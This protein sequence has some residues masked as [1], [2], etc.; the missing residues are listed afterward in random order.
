MN[1]EIIKENSTSLEELLKEAFGKNVENINIEDCLNKNIRF[2]CAK[3]DNEVV[4]TIMI[5]TKYNPVR[6]TK[7]FYLDYVCVKDSCRNS[8]VGTLMLQELDKIAREERVKRIILETS[9]QREA[10]QHLYEKNNYI[11]K[12]AYIYYKEIGE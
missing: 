9:F 2:L 1:I 6:G 11:K 12:D 4:G 7:D 10:A 5:T 8:G 3:K